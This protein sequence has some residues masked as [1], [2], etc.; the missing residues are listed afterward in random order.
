M[1]DHVE[2]IKSYVSTH[3]YYFCRLFLVR[4][5][6][7]A[8]DDKVNVLVGEDDVGLGVCVGLAFA[9]RF[10]ALS[11]ISSVWFSW[12]SSDISVA[13]LLI[14]FTIVTHERVPS[15]NQELIMVSIP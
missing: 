14:P 5:R 7:I 11:P 15:P 1:Y 2:A 6:S 9:T 10:P 4:R 12:V 8:A 3:L 13:Y